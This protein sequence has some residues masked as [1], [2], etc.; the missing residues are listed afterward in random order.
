[1]RIL[2]IDI[3]SLRPD[4]LGCY[5]YHRNTSPNI[6]RIADGARRFT[7]YYTSDAPCVPS[8]TALF[9]SRF[10]IHTGVINHGGLNASMRPRGS[11]RDFNLQMDEYRTWMTAL[12]DAGLHTALVSVFPQHH[13]AIQVLDG[14]DEWHHTDEFRSDHVYPYAEEWIEN[15]AADD[16]WYLHVNFWDPHTP[17]NTPEDFGYPF[18]DEP[19]PEWPDQETIEDHYESYG[20]HSAQD[21][22]GW[23]GDT[24]F[25]RT[26]EE[27]SNREEYKQYVDGYDVGIRYVDEYIGK[28]LDQL[29]A[30]GVLDETLI[31]VSADHGEN[32]GELNVYGDHHT[33]D[34]KTC[35]VPLIVD[36]PGVE[37]GVDEEFHYQIDL[38]P[39]ITEFVDGDVPTGWDGRSFADSLT[40]GADDT[41]RDYL[42]VSQAPWSC[43]RG[44]RWDDW[45]LLRTYHDGLKDFD[46]VELYDLDADPHETTNLAQEK[47]DVARKG[48]ALLDEWVSTRLMETARDEA[49]GNADAPRALTDPMLEVLH[50]GGPF[51]ARPDEQLES[52]AE[53]LRETGR[54]EHAAALEET[55]G[56]VDQSIDAYLGGE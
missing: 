36:G 45:L 16:D 46:P 52:Y 29:E 28:L 47:P 35:R 55:R 24:P 49:G 15:N 21:V 38:A 41:G 53:R 20:P 17:Y 34:D 10:G 22:H 42:V 6:D 48:I 18:E 25:P 19:A 50:E 7:N 3:D 12:R 39:T 56:F 23:G 44:V 30:E 33:A 13:G 9:T 14:F 8:R 37:P 54:A 31:I 5:G 11:G 2:Y 51:H 32:M 40:E 1:M 43:Q 27:I 26:P 4:H